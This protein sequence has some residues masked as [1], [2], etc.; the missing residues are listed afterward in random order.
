MELEPMSVG[1][2]PG[3]PARRQAIDLGRVG[4]DEPDPRR[5][6]LLESRKVEALCLEDRPLVARPTERGLTDRPVTPDHAVT[7]HDQRD[8][9]VPERGPDGAD[10]PGPADLGGDPAVRTD[11]AARDLERLQPDVAFELRMPAKV[12]VDVR[13]SISVEPARDRGGQSRWE[14]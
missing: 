9:V 2:A 14:S 7:G 12:E 13:A 6:Q 10:R 8:G 11:L 1:H 5:R 4:T 3:V